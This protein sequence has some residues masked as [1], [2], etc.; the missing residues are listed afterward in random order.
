MR[1]GRFIILAISLLCSTL[2]GAQA[3]AKPLFA[4]EK[5]GEAGLRLTLTVGEVHF[6]PVESAEGYLSV[7]STGL[8]TAACREGSP[9]LPVATRLVRLPRGSRLELEALETRHSEKTLTLPEGM[10]AAPAIGPWVK[11]SPWPGYNPDEKIYHAN[12]YYRGGE[13]VEIEDL[14]IMGPW[15]LFRLTVRPMAYNPIEGQLSVTETI[16]SILKI[17]P[18]SATLAEQL[19]GSQ[20]MLIVSRHEFREGLQPFVRWKRQEGYDV[21]ELYVSTHQRDSIKA[22]MRPWFDNA[23]PLSPAPGYILLVGDAAQI[24]SFI[25]QTSLEGESHTTDLY[26]ADYTGDYLPEALLGRWPVNDTAEL[27]TVVEKTLR[28]EQFIGIDTMQLKRLMLVAGNE[29]ATP[30]PL[31]TNS[32]VE[33]IGHEALLAHPE[34]D[35]VTYRNPQSGNLLDSIK[36]DIGHGA[37]LLNYTAHCTVGGWTSPSLTIGR[38]EEANGD[39]PMVYVNN[40]CKSNT[41]SGTGFGEQL[42]RLPVGGAVG[43]IGATNSTLWY[44]DYYWAVGPKWPVSP[45]NSYDSLARGAFDALVG[46][47]PSVATLGGLMTAG[48]LAVTSFGSGYSRFYWEIYC[49]LGDPTLR[50]WIGV[51]QKIELA[52]TDSLRNGDN[53]IAVSAT[54]GTRV[55]AM[56]GDVLLGVADINP[57]GQTTL[58]LCQTLDTLP[59]ILTATGPGLQP[60]IDTLTVSADVR[61]GVALRQV[62]VDDTVV[63]CIVE[64]IGHYSIDSLKV[65]LTQAGDDTVHGALLQWQMAVIDSL[66][67]GASQA[68]ALPVA[69]EA[70]GAQ[71][72]WQATLMAW[73]A[74]SGTLCDL[75]LLHALEVH[76]PTLAL[77]L[78]DASGRAAKRLRAARSYRLEA[79]IEG[80]Y[81]N[82]RLEAETLPTGPLYTTQD[83]TLDFVTGDSLCA[84]H[85][86]ATLGLERWAERK[87]Y[88]LEPGDR[89]DGFEQGF[90]SHPWQNDGRQPW[91]LDSAESHSGR[92]SLRSGTIGDGQATRFCLDVDM[93]HRDS[94]VF[95]VKTSTEAQH[96]RMVFSVDGIDY[97]PQSW[98]IGDWRERAYVLTAGRHR[99]CW[100]YVKDG[101]QSD[102]ED[103][104]WIDDLQLP[105]ALWDSAYAWTCIATTV[106]IPT[107]ERHGGM[108]ISPNPTTSTAT[109][110]GEAGTEVLITDAV[111]RRIMALTLDR[112]AQRVDLGMLPAGIYFAIGNSQGYLTTE[113]II[114]TKQ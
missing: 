11:D 46:R 26:Y 2:A 35:T 70:I 78:T 16:T 99:L 50:P 105:L 58:R 24:Q 1:I 60:R 14:G 10:L 63:N 81:D 30:A 41:F 6:V 48:N 94:I 22:A 13:E 59:L 27:R 31:T 64:N 82:L 39:Q 8:A 86:T 7:E 23:T 109:I 71:P 88:W 77:R 76:Y 36:A 40:C 61:Y 29:T 17:I 20:R 38:V 95:W 112:T 32:Q 4:L 9:A 66:P 69:I 80:Y 53:E 73:E 56:Q 51:P 89:R 84:L 67:A 90:A 33:Y 34:M 100:Q 3:G 104:V 65:V 54:R 96:D 85:I 42:L 97:T 106:D 79:T 15:Q 47:H 110:V 75:T 91:V 62:T 92:Y 98:G 21:A 108:T 28:Y 43:V 37:S 72:Y 83:S 19:E 111:G 93:P 57:G 107:T 12:S 87:D 44:E 18:P 5:A 101:S 45:A 68:I 25:G 55:T 74:G 103:A 114:V 52:V 102:G 49:L 113:K